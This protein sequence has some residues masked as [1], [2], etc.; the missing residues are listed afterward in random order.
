MATPTHSHQAWTEKGITSIDSALVAYEIFAILGAFVL[1]DL[2]IRVELESV[3]S[4]YWSALI[5]GLGILQ[6]GR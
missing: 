2:W 5:T 6:V 3:D 1:S 4:V